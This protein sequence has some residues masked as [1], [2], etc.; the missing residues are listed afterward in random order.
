MRIEQEINLEWK[1]E[2][3]EIKEKENH[4]F[5]VGFSGSLISV[6]VCQKDVDQ[7]FFLRKIILPF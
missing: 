4:R 1:N 5:V 2:E 3:E 7:R 6:S